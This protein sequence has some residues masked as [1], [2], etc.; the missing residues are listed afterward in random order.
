MKAYV[1]FKNGNIKFCNKY[2]N[3]KFKNGSVSAYL[4]E[5]SHPV[6]GIFYVAVKPKQMRYLNKIKRS[7][8]TY[9]FLD[10]ILVDPEEDDYLFERN[11]YWYNNQSDLLSK[12]LEIVV[13][14]NIFNDSFWIYDSFYQYIYS[15]LKVKLKTKKKNK[16]IIKSN[17]YEKLIGDKLTI[18]ENIIN[19][20]DYGSY[21]LTK[22]K[23]SSGIPF[24]QLYNNVF[25]RIDSKI[26]DYGKYTLTSRILLCQDNME[27]NSRTE[28]G[29]TK[30]VIDISKLLE[31]YTS[32]KVIS[33]LESYAEDQIYTVKTTVKL[34][35]KKKKNKKLKFNKFINKYFVDINS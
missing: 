18:K 10:G 21:K 16:T 29:N 11:K 30:N 24:V 4:I 15:D 31:A 5:C 6:F 34:T 28:T 32:K 7:V 25:F 12:L 19:I 2:K 9:K 1:L 26:F 13:C 35:S 23:K 20:S 14:E 8:L 3:S 17:L 33:K 22:I 27:L